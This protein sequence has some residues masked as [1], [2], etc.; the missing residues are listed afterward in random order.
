MNQDNK[1]VSQKG[2]KVSVKITLDQAD[3][4][5]S[6]QKHLHKVAGEMSVRGFRK[7][8]H[9][10]KMREIERTKGPMVRVE[11]IDQMLQES[12][13][14][15]IKAHNHSLA[16]RPEM[17]NNK[18]DGV[19]S[20]IV[21]QMSYEVFSEIPDVDLSK[22]SVEVVKSEVH[23][24]NIAEEI[25]KLR[26]H[27][28]EWVAVDRASKEGDQ[29]KIDFVGRLDGELFDGGSATDQT[30]EIGAGQFLPDFEK[31]LKKVKAGEEKSF[32]VNFPKE[33][34]SEKLAGK[35]AG[36]DVKVLSV[37]EKKPLDIG[38]KLFE[39]SDSTATEVLDFEKEIKSRLETDAV[40][41]A[42]AINRKRM[43]VVLKKK[44]IF[45]LPE[46]TLND[47][48]KALQEKDSEMK[49]KVA[50]QK[51]TDSLTMALILRHYIQTYQVKAT[52]ED[53]RA[54]IAI[55]APG[56]MSVDSFYEWYVQDQS[57]LNQV[58]AA[59]IEQNAL[60]KL[61]TLVKTKEVVCSIKDIEKELK[62]GV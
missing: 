30:I 42:N 16:S 34:Q 26:E 38:K 13:N 45:P 40:H 37:S 3:V 25:D 36:F 2:L 24:D 4:A 19:D 47:E 41:L 35:K 55:G 54:Y 60:D 11:V 20:N 53:V 12:L 56:Q 28:G 15:V 1:Q 5:K 59:V 10:L 33:Y 62:E 6:Y 50:K 57:R 39:L 44:I 23:Q 17:V 18:G 8:A 61:L 21:C 43:S 27:H 9:A 14:E 48:V 32:N 29:L 46:C 49:D 7:S 22:L 31:N 52:E 51:A 58:Q